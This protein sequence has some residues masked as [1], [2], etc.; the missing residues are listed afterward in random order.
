MVSALD[1]RSGSPG[2][3]PHQGHCVVFSAKTLY[4]HSVSLHPDAQ[5]GTGKFNAGGQPYNGLASHPGN[6]PSRFMLRK[7]KL[8]TGLMSHLG[9]NADF[10][11]HLVN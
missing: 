5:R 9:S 4:S 6:A 11:Y 3:S 8:S 7:P 10:T 2:S 1:S